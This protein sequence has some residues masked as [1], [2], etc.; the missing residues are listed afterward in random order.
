LKPK[1]SKISSLSGV[2]YNLRKI[3]LNPAKRASTAA[4]LKLCAA[5]D[6]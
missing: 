6:S 2:G 1:E 3:I 5:R 4:V